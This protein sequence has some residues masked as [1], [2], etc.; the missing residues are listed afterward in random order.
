MPN[1]TCTPQPQTQ[2]PKGKGPLAALVGT[3]AAIA[4]LTI[5]PKDESGRT[6]EVTVEDDGT[7]TS[8]HVSGKQY[9]EAY[10]DMV[11]VVTI[12]DGDTSDVRRGQVATEAECQA[13]LER[14]L[15][16]HAKP[17]LRCVPALAH[18]DRQNQLIASVS[19]AYNIGPSGFCGSSVARRFN[20][21]QWATGCHN[22][23]LWNKVRVNGRLVP[24]R[25]LTLRR[26]RERKL[27]LEGL[28]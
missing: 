16:A 26:A 9:L 25:G 28:V 19:L 27:C 5:I 1:P 7:I 15:V 8:R 10:V 22:M 2:T 18:P 13:R 12:C 23:M 24:V 3:A 20:R 4:L 21:G 14:Q 17:V 6:V 11:G